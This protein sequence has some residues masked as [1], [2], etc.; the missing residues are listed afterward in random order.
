MNDSGYGSPVKNNEEIRFTIES[1]KPGTIDEIVASIYET[2]KD[3][4]I[5]RYP[6]MNVQQRLFWAKVKGHEDVVSINPV[7]FLCA[8]LQPETSVQIETN[9]GPELIYK[10]PQAFDGKNLCWFCIK[11]DNRKNCEAITHLHYNVY[12]CKDLCVVA[13]DGES[14]M[15]ALVNDGRFKNINKFQLDHGPRRQSPA[16]T[17]R[18]S[19]YSKVV[20]RV[21]VTRSA[22]LDES[23]SSSNPEVKQLVLKTE[24]TVLA[25]ASSPLSAA[26][27]TRDAEA[28]YLPGIHEPTGD[29]NLQGMQNE[30]FPKD[31]VV[32]Q[33]EGVYYFSKPVQQLSNKE[34]FKEMEDCAKSSARSMLVP[35]DQ[36]EIAKLCVEQFAYQ[37]SLARPAWLTKKLGPLL[38]SVGRIICGSVSATCFLITHDMLITN[39]HVV[40]MITNAR[41]SD[42][43]S[44]QDIFVDFDFERPGPM[45]I[46]RMIK[47]S[48]RNEG[49][50]LD[51]SYDY[52]L[53]R[54]EQNVDNKDPLGPKVRCLVPEEG[55]I[56]I[57][58]HPS[59]REK[60]GETGVIL[61][62][63]ARS[64]E[65]GR[66]VAE[67][68]ARCSLNPEGCALNQ[69]SY[70]TRCIHM[71]RID[72]GDNNCLMTYDV[73]SMFEGSSGS[74]IFNMNAEIVAMHSAG[75]RLNE[76]KKKTSVVEFGITFEAIIG[77]LREKGFGEV[78]KQIF[79]NCE[80]QDMDWF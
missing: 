21:T 61:P 5:R 71:Y 18:A 74:P 7:M 37:H 64:E 69:R 75:F 43:S 2:V 65:L 11:C 15:E 31:Q 58:G 6:K 53:L 54:L 70:N 78:V 20:F 12:R 59:N 50:I 51:P 40:N 45:D 52:A 76:K 9:P 1:N 62:R 38:D 41:Q 27:V 46:S 3:A 42:L 47:V 14:I 36:K 60:L 39:W 19:S 30:S 29:N 48:P 17:A 55:L 35:D 63:I 24:Q 34:M 25:D 73:G 33:N 16:I 77:S 49:N 22:K 10:K 66:R 56:T 79:P 13:R 8:W 4:L 32:V 44:H 67:K 80:I 26:A 23:V 72:V 68:A 28:E 57:I